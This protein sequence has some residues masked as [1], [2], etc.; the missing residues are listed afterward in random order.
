MP[1]ATS[2]TRGPP[3]DGEGSGVVTPDAA[4]EAETRPTSPADE[5][6]EPNEL[7]DALTEAW[8]AARTEGGDGTEKPVP[9]AEGWSILQS[10][11]CVP[12]NC[13]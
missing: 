3:G 1:R 8:T 9:N 5:P 7:L 13:G 2:S 12:M 6:D 10:C 4:D 11:Y